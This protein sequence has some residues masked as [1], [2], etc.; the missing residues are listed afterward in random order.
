MRSFDAWHLPGLKADELEIASH[1]FGDLEVR[2]P[3]LSPGQLERVIAHIGHAR[4]TLRNAPADEIIR[5]IDAAAHTIGNDPS[6]RDLLCAVTGYSR[7]NV[8][9]I[10]E[11]MVADWSRDSLENLLRSELDGPGRPIGPRLAFHIFSGNVPGVAVTSMIRSMLV[12][13][14][15]FGKTASGE[16]VLPV[17]FARALQQTA[18]ALA[19]SLAVTYW[20]GGTEELET[21]AIRAADTIVVYG[22]A[23][24][25][26]QVAARAP[27]GTNLVVHGPKLSIGLVGRAAGLDVAAPIARAVAAYDQ[28]GCVSPHVVY[29]ER[30]GALDARALARA[31]AAE[32]ET[33]SVSIP[34]RALDAAEAIAIRDARTRAEFRDNA[35]VFGPDETTY[36]VI[37]DEDATLTASCLN[38]TLYVKVIADVSSLRSVLLPHRSVMQSVGVAGFTEQEIDSLAVMLGD[39][40]VTRITTFEAL[41]WPPM[42]WHHDGRGPL[43]E[44]LLWQDIAT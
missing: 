12:R 28:Q 21:A 5:A 39:V 20:P 29:V 24:T 18:P 44:L 23:E 1:R 6:T 7:Q 17:L 31:V 25:V 40:G 13:A 4:E 37:Y 14:A 36:T 34:R 38:R 9:S 19:D 41:P 43:R 32:L 30:G 10:L 11:H 26:R 3:E 15:T 8:D 42:T 22:G 2:A 27:A 16:P 35:E 33:L